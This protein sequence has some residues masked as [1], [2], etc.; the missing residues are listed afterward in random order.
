MLLLSLLLALA[1]VVPAA[2]DVAADRAA[3]I[4][5]AQ[6]T[7]Q[8]AKA[9]ALEAR[10]KADAAT[11]EKVEKMEARK[12]LAAIPVHAKDSREHTG[13]RRAFQPHWHEKEALL[14]LLNW[15]H[16]LLAAKRNGTRARDLGELVLTALKPDAHS[17]VHPEEKALVDSEVAA[18]R[19][20][21]GL[22]D[23]A[24][25]LHHGYLMRG[26]PLRWLQR[27]SRRLAEHRARI[28]EL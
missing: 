12:A 2:G 1:A 18:M 3:A 25:L 28:D 8:R 20:E 7:R 19:E 6:A 11:S 16:G 15:A 23:D 14:P 10:A 26:G 21:E 13:K 17:V 24:M 9:R 4:A 22:A 5:R 27:V